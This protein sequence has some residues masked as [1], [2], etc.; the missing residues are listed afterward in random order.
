MN[1]P[2]A[3]PA[4]GGDRGDDARVADARA[5]R[6]ASQVAAGIFISRLAGLVRIRVVSYYLGATFAADAYNNAMRIP[7]AV[8]NLLGEGTISASFIPVYSALLGKGEERVARALAGALLG[9]LLAAVSLLTILGITFAPALTHVFVSADKPET[10]ALTIRLVRVMFPMT[11]LMVMSGWCL[12]V[13]NSHRR[14][15]NSYASAALWS[16]AQIVLLVGWGHRAADLT[17]LAWWLAWATLA[18]AVLQVGAQ[19]PQVLSLVRPLRLSV[20]LASPGVTETLRNFIPVVTALGLVQ[21]SSFIDLKIAGL[22]PTGAVTEVSNAGQLYMLPIS[23]FGLSVAA[24]S[25][26]EFAREHRVAQDLLLERLRNGWVRILFYVVPTSVAFVAFGNHFI[27]LLFQTGRF[28]AAEARIVWMILAG[29][30]LGLVAYSSVRLLA[31]AFYAMRDYR[32]PL[33]SSLASITTSAALA[34]AL[35]LP[36]RQ[37]PEAAAALAIGSATGA[38]LNLALLARGLRARLGPL[39]TPVMW[40]GTWRIVAATMGAALVSGLV[41]YALRS[42]HP[43]VTALG[44]LFAFGAAYVLVAAR[45]GSGE[46]NRLLQ[47]VRMGRPPDVP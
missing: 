12:G 25:L 36:N 31:S 2:P 23:L 20:N 6:S 37:H 14:F 30:S 29:Y 1:V 7:N 40:R 26:P 39:Y 16:I 46:A 41:N 21:I 34:L 8:R 33:R 10:M 28:G 42:V 45:T 44:T 5:S 43:V 13:Q 38:Y 32:T 27:R 17:Q 3:P 47:R 24:S 15:F 11:G 4:H 19:L 18:G 22:L 35:A 9:V